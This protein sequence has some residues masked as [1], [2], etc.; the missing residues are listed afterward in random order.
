MN[1]GHKYCRKSIDQ[2]DASSANLGSESN[3][4]IMVNYHLWEKITTYVNVLTNCGISLVRKNNNQIHV[5]TTW[6]LVN[7]YMNYRS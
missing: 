7:S 2:K 3:Y 6:T 1:K 4:S 5:L